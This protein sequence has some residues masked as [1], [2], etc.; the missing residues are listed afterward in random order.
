MRLPLGLQCRLLHIGHARSKKVSYLSI[1]Y[2]LQIKLSYHSVSFNA[3]DEDR[4]R[5]DPLSLHGAD[6]AP[7]IWLGSYHMLPVKQDGHYWA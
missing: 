6:Q 1:S 5:N 7:H 4:N 3:V 2:I